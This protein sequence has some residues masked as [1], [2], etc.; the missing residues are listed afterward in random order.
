MAIPHLRTVIKQDSIVLELCVASSPALSCILHLTSYIT[1]LLLPLHC[2]LLCRIARN[3]TAW[4]HKRIGTCL[5]SIMEMKMARFYFEH[6]H[7]PADIDHMNEDTRF[8]QLTAYMP[9]NICEVLS[10]NCDIAICLC[11]SSN[12]RSACL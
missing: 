5:S 2:L 9:E 12:S 7:A 11:C 8:A 4:N 3:K 6:M 10:L 1:G